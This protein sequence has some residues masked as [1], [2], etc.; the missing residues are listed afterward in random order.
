VKDAARSTQGTA[1]QGSSRDRPGEGDDSGVEYVGAPASAAQPIGY[2]KGP[3]NLLD[4]NQPDSPP[5]DG[6]VSP[7]EKEKGPG[8]I[9]Q[10]GSLPQPLNIVDLEPDVVI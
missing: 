7:G 4:S 6:E 2:L 5:H 10:G 8:G 3:R 9:G 1:Q